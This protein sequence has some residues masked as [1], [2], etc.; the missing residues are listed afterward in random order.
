[1]WV[2]L[3]PFHKYWSGNETIACTI[4]IALL[5]TPPM[6]ACYYPLNTAGAAGGHRAAALWRGEDWHSS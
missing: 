3:Y 1:M 2:D 4:I 6:R 5:E